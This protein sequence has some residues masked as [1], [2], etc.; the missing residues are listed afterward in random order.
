MLIFWAGWQPEMSLWESGSTNGWLR[1]NIK[2]SVSLFSISLM[3][4]RCPQGAREVMILV[5][6]HKARAVG[7][8]VKNAGVI[9]NVNAWNR[10]LGTITQCCNAFQVQN[11]LQN[12]IHAEISQ[13]LGAD[14]SQVSRGWHCVGYDLN[15][16]SF[17]S[18]QYKYKL[19]YSTLLLQTCLVDCSLQSA[20]K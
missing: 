16:Y 1:E 6:E 17:F 19:I 20:L 12:P 13:G 8:A 3:S 11:L 18:I 15:S 9:Q 4:P 10:I 2:P 14:E 7:C 5:L